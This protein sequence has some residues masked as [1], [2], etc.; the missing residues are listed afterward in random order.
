MELCIWVSLE[1]NGHGN[2]WLKIGRFRGFESYEVLV[3]NW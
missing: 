3:M 1:E 2:L